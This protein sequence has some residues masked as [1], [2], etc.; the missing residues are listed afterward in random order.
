MKKIAKIIALAVCAGSVL[1]LSACSGCSGTV[2]RSTNTSPNWLLRGSTA[3]DL[4]ASSPLMQNTETA[5]YSVS[6]EAGGNTNYSVSYSEDGSYKTELSATNYDWSQSSIPTELRAEGQTDCVYTYVTELSLPV[7]F[8]VGGE[9]ASFT[10]EITTVSYFRSAANNLQP[11]YSRQQIHCYTPN[12]I[13]PA[14]VELAYVEMNITY[15][16][17]YSRDGGTA[18]TKSS[19]EDGS[20]KTAGT[21]TPYSLFDASGL[22]VALRS[23]TQKGTHTFNVYVPSNGAAATYTASWGSAADI[24]ADD[25]NFA[26]IR[27]ALNAACD[28]GY[29]LTAAGEDGARTFNYTPVTVSLTGAMSG[30]SNTYYFAT[31]KNSDLNTG[32]AVMLRMEEVVPFNLGTI[33]YSL[34]SV[35]QEVSS[36][37]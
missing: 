4:D 21:A 8:T 15:E 37:A 14:T 6:F 11:V 12:S 17:W 1:T 30:P 23:F 16:T 19:A 24:A 35:S 20:T 2:D 28:S 31:V 29:L 27:D 10:N 9:S 34:K 25:E 3:D 5:T 36:A 18:V 13:N 32:R 7:T 33:I 26:G 22:A